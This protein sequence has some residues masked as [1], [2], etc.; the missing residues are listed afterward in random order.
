MSL[1]IC[2]L[3]IDVRLFDGVDLGRAQL[4][5]DAIESTAGS[6]ELLRAGRVMRTSVDLTRVG[7]VIGADTPK[8]EPLERVSRGLTTGQPFEQPRRKSR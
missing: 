7:G 1:S 3:G 2:R 8:S 6:P 4:V 5:L